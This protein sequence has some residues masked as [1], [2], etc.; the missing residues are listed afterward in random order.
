MDDHRMDRFSEACGLAGP[1][2]VRLEGITPQD[3]STP[4]FHRPFLVVGRGECADV[5]IDHPE[6]SRRHAYFQVLAG[7]VFCVDLSSRTGVRWADGARPVG[8][9]DRGRGVEVGPSRLRFEGVEGAEGG[10]LPISKAFDWPTLPDARLEF[11]GPNPERP[12]WQVSRALVLLGR[13]PT[14]RVLLPGRGVGKIHA[15][16]LRT[17]AG[18]WVVDLHDPGGLLVGG[19]PTRCA[20]LEDG[21]EIGLGDQRLR[22]RIGPAAV[23]SPVRSD[24]A[25]RSPG[26]G[27]RHAPRTAGPSTGLEERG[28]PETSGRPDRPM[29]VDPMAA[30]L[31]DEFD[32]MHRRTTEQ[33]QQALLMMFRMHQDQ[34][35]VIRDELS[36]IDRLEDELRSLQAELARATLPRPPRIALRLV[37]GEPAPALPRPDVMPLG[38]TS[39]DPVEGASR[40]PADALVP[41]VE[42]GPSPA[43][44]SGEGVPLPPPDLHARLAERIARIQNERQGMW[45]RIVASLTN[46]VTRQGL[47]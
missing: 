12:P 6:V 13:S 24:L 27:V 43:N 34:M 18:I 26:R 30:R 22:I 46:D 39:P 19:A 4:E 1:L 37:S 36:R 33:F 11:V 23:R 29:V 25:R 17:P 44:R 47:P 5:R 9:V 35:E 15:A 2:R 31:L 41:P 16:L 20:R 14:C 40:H 45:K 8:W 28:G 21:D 32:R 10:A 3:S 42:M 38:R 7:R